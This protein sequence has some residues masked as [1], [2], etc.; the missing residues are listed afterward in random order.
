ML[1]KGPSEWKLVQMKSKTTE[2]V[3]S[4]FIVEFLTHS[5]IEDGMESFAIKNLKK[6]SIHVGIQL[7]STEVQT[8]L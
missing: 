4:F 6:C 7:L 3:Y 2:S 5:A 8:I 1:V